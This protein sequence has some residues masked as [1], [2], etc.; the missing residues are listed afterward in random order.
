MM[1]SP[2]PV[3]PGAHAPNHDSM[4]TVSL[5]NSEHSQPDWRTLDIPPTPIEASHDI[6]ATKMK[7]ESF[8]PMPLQDAARST[9]TPRD[10]PPTPTSLADGSG[11]DTRGEEDT[12]TEAD[13]ENLDKTEEQEPR[14]ESSDESTA[15]LLARLEQENNAL[16][17]NPKSGLANN[18]TPPNVPHI[19]RHQRQSRSQSLVQIKKLINDPGRSEL[20]FS[21]LQPP[22]M[23][24]LEFWA[25]LVADYPQTAQRLPTLTSNK[26][27]GGVPPPLR[28]VVWPS[29]AGARD[30]SLLD[31][32]QRL[33][34]ES[35]PYDGLIGKDIGRS[36][37]N[38]EMFRD[39][40]GEGQQ[41]LA[42]VLRCFS[43]YDAKIGYCQ[44]L[45][46]V[47]GPLL[48]HMSDAE[49]F[50]VLVR[51][52]D[53]Y[54]LRTCYLPDLSGLHLHV[55]QF[56]NLLARHRPALFEHLESLSVEPVYVSQ[57][58]LSFFA[59]A[60]PLPML[61]RIY[62]V[63]FLEGACETLMRVALSLMQRNERRILACT[64]FED[65]M[66]LLL[67]RSLWDTYAFNAD[68][69][70]NDFVS[71]TPLVT[72]ESLQA[73]EASYN[74]SQG[75]QTGISFPQ[76]Q[77]AASRFLGRLWAGSNSHHSVRSLNPN[78]TPSRPNSTIRRSTSKQ[79]MT[80]TLNSVETT[81]DA[82]TAPTELTAATASLD[83]PKARIKSNMSTHH[84]DRDLH[85]QIEDLLMALSD[86]QRQH[87][88]LTLE[89][90]QER[91][92]REEDHALAKEMLRQI[93]EPIP[94]DQ[95]TE[96]ISK[97]RARFAS[98]EPKSLS[99]TQ[100]KQQL[101]DDMTRW[102]EMH[103]VES[104]RCLN[105]TR[106]MDDFEKDNSSLKDQ[107]RE[108]RSRI[109]DG[110]RDRQR[111]ERM[112]Q[113]LR[114]LKIAEPS[115]STSDV[116]CTSPDSESSSPTGLRELKLVRTNSHKSPTFNKRSSSL[117]LQ[118][119]LVT[120]N[121]K[122]AA[123]ETLL[124]ELVNAKTAEAVAKQELEE[125][126][127]KLDALRKMISAPHTQNVSKLQNRH[128]FI[129]NSP[130]TTSISKSSPEPVKTPGTSTNVGS[131]GGG[132]FSGWGRRAAP[133]GN[134]S[135]N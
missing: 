105:L 11:E 33:S 106:R 7:T 84:K 9:P 71:L 112:N 35:S 8:G 92:E 107:L 44:G 101:Y 111:L 85:T 128:S 53:H 32:F 102:K 78:P 118:N 116:S 37:P 6:E 4:V 74:Q 24:E 77:A 45:G 88:D 115:A 126:K 109:Q 51:L 95:T 125:V 26:I 130:S 94:G 10:E 110:Y 96:L 2:A 76:M 41:M 82:S 57:W 127:G 58:F 117:G 28:G 23:T 1:E 56:Q 72:K 5:S 124:L 55:Y 25:A 83:S 104:S 70:V 131:G 87:A 86:L 103:E 39:P 18:P 65:V 3:S 42:R 13:W 119:V 67:S 31:D 68:D 123:E 99:I 50:C 122:P 12:D 21:Q 98:S 75:V 60:C 64:E 17:T 80:S 113:E 91:E 19:Q 29:L 89:L 69:L 49:A 66:Q 15:L 121:N 34:G 73:L 47:V 135:P 93:Q 120:E 22:P 62:D 133:A 114:S 132:F 43:L 14:G 63:I 36:F 59:V 79:S 129:G 100:T 108:A 38:V 134:E 46:F 90:Q 40:N 20:R 61:L 30:P 48:M 54:N 27:Q 52:M 16:A 97:A 81:S